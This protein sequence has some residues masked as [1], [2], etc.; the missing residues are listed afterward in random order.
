MDTENFS[1]SP[2]DDD[3]EFLLDL[4]QEFAD[5]REMEFECEDDEESGVVFEF[6]PEEE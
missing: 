6:E 3:Q 5:G 1:F 2:E 4:N